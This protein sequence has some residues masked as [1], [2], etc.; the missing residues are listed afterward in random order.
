[1]QIGATDSMGDSRSS[2]GTAIKTSKPR[3]I[4]WSYSITSWLGFVPFFIFCLL[5]E[6]LPAVMVV[7]NSF[8]D[9]NTGAFTL[10]NYQRIFL[11]PDKLHAFENS[12]S[13][14]IVTALIGGVFGFIAAYGIYNLR[15]KWLHNLIVGFS[16]V[17]ANFAGVPLAFAFIATLG[18]TG[19]IT[20]LFINWFHIDL[21][22]H[23]FS[24]YTFAGL[25]LVYIYF[26][27]PLMILL[28]IPALGAIRP[29]WREASTN[30]G[31]SNFTYWRRIALPILFPSLIAAMLLLFANSFGAFATAYALGQGNINLVPIQISFVVNGNVSLDTG[32]GNALA[33]G[34]IAVLLIAVIFYTA[35][36]RRISR[37]QGR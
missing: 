2:S 4:N 16:S 1:M 12:I 13:I 9:S 15:T 27:L 3:C 34:M 29:E 36:L 24:L 37:W 26:Q 20:T 33:A 10:N 30:L 19:F 11:E 17:A 14:S 7:Q 32:L 18:V 22:S 6:L 31:A 21:Y 8:V 23:G 5:F 25:I 35:M 28:T